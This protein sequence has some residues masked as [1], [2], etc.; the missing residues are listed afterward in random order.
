ML[1]GLALKVFDGEF[2]SP[3]LWSGCAILNTATFLPSFTASIVSPLVNIPET[4]DIS[5]SFGS[6]S[7]LLVKSK[8]G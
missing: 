6:K 5:I 7:I 2:I 8:N 3:V 4:I 1:N